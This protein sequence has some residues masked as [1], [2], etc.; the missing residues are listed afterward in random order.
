MMNDEKGF[1]HVRLRVDVEVEALKVATV[2]YFQD[3]HEE[4]L[5]EM[6]GQFERY[7]TPERIK[8]EVRKQITTLIR[9]QLSHMISSALSDAVHSVR[10]AIGGV[11][12]NHA[13]RALADALHEMFSPDGLTARE[14]VDKELRPVEADEKG[15]T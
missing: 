10:G 11:V 14:E 12:R 8:L 6:K 5:T 15:R 2:R 3:Y 7:V 9:D 13:S 1:S 4:M